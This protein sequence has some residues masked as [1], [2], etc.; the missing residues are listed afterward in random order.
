[1]KNIFTIALAAFLSFSAMAQTLT[2]GCDSVYVTSTPPPEQNVYFVNV[3]YKQCGGPDACCRTITSGSPATPRF[4]LEQK[5]DN[6][7]WSQIGGQQYS[8][9]FDNLGYGTYRVRMNMPVVNWNHCGGGIPTTCYNT[10]G[11]FIGYWGM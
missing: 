7:S 4:F 9:L 1:M 10:L 8:P 5:Q 11:Q 3:Y 2:G 6:G